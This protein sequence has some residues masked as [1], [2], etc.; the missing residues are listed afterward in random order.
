MEAVDSD[1]HDRSGETGVGVA[2]PLSVNSTMTSQRKTRIDL[3]SSTSLS[4]WGSLA[5]IVGLGILLLLTQGCA[6][7]T[8]MMSVGFATT[9]NTVP[10]TS[11]DPT[12]TPAP[13]DPDATPTP[14]ATPTPSPTSSPDSTPT[15]AP[16]PALSCG[17]VV[18]RD[19]RISTDD[20]NGPELNFRPWADLNLADPNGSTLNDVPLN[21]GTYNRVRF[22]MHK[23]TGEGSGGPGTGNPD[24]N[25]SIHVCGTWQGVTFDV[26]NDITDN[27]DRRD[28]GGVTVDADG[29]GKLFVIFD[30]STWFNGIDLTQA[31]IAPDGIAYLNH[32]SN[33]QMAQQFKQNFKDSVHLANDLHR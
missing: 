26:F 30:S 13:T 28:P 16:T 31:S 12:P 7:R 33:K 23:R 19:L 17:T 22:T 4:T 2:P 3:P 8:S 5:C 20:A 29:P 9:D 10:G 18:I 27:V 21:P 24:V 1:F 6:N 32:S 11:A 14:T 25:G 15:P